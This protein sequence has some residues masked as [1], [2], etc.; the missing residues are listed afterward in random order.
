MDARAGAE[1]Y[2]AGGFFAF[3]VHGPFGNDARRDGT[4]AEVARESAFYHSHEGLYLDAEVLGFDPL[5][6]DQP[7]LSLAL[8]KRV[9]PPGLILHVI[10]RRTEDGKLVPRQKVAVRLPVNRE[11]VRV[12]VVSPDWTGEQPGSAHR[13][14]TGLTVELPRVEAYSVAILDYDSLPEVKLHGRRIVPAQQW[15]RP[16]RNEFVLEPGGLLRDQWA[17]PGM[18]QGNLHRELRNPPHFL[19]NMPRGGSMR[20][21]VRGVATLGTDCSG[22]STASLNRRSTC[23]TATARTR[24]RHRST[25]RPSA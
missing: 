1:I 22:R 23:P 10:N 14:G 15:T 18:L 16:A 19:V 3:P 17:L 4:L 6:S 24:P 2:A 9:S 8:W 25:T 21:H 7:Q 11:P 13:S 12:R 20:V 5:E